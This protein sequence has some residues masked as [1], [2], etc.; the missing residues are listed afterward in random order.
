LLK[1][2]KKK[3]KKKTEHLRE[4]I[5]FDSASQTDFRDFIRWARFVSRRFFVIISRRSFRE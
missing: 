3:K 1:K 4:D 2:R 5:F